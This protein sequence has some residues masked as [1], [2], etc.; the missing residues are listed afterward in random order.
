[1]D[2][3]PLLY[4]PPPPPDDHNTQGDPRPARFSPPPPPLHPPFHPLYQLLFR[5]FDNVYTLTGPGAPTNPCP[6]ISETSFN[7]ANPSRPSPILLLSPLFSPPACAHPHPR[8]LPPPPPPAPPLP[9]S[10]S[11]PPPH[12]GP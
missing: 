8:S 9:P 12:P 10:P 1:M 2:P 6:F 5:V 4:S 11:S 7:P 3:L